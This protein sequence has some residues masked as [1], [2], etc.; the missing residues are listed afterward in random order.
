MITVLSRLGLRC[1]DAGDAAEDVDWPDGTIAVHSKGNRIDRLPLPV[2][3]GEAVVD[4]L[5][6]GRPDTVARAVFVR[7][8]APRTALAPSSAS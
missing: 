4:Y 2:G 3:V 8:Y 5:R 1:A 7:V 6:H